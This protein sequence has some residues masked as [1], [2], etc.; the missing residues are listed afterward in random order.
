M[1]EGEEYDLDAKL[2]EL[3]HAFRRLKAASLDFAEAFNAELA[4]LKKQA[5]ALLVMPVDIV[6]K[7]GDL[8]VNTLEGRCKWKGREVPLSTTEL[9][10]VATM[11]KRPDLIYE[12]AYLMEAFC[13]HGESDRLVD[14][15]LKRVRHK[16]GAVDPLF[17]QIVT[18]YGAGYRWNR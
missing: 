10:I 3:S 11:A 5:E 14:S 1:T 2:T 15:H 18:I 17:D 9:K 7:V 12:R 16:F 4:G 13:P 8:E 6:T